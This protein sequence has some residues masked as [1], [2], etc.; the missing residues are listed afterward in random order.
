MRLGLVLLACVSMCGP[1]CA[2]SGNAAKDRGGTRMEITADAKTVAP[3]LE[4]YA[5]GP[6]TG[7]GTVM[8]SRSVTA[9]SLRYLP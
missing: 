6:L 5:Q 7:L 3:A 8:N 1:G 4:K 9:A 2:Q